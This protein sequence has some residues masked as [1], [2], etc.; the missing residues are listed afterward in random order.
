M[1]LCQ[2]AWD[3]TDRASNGQSQN[4]FSNKT[5]N[6]QIAYNPKYKPNIIETILKEIN[7]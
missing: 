4:N 6:T 3:P 1:E 5:N 2:G 7:D